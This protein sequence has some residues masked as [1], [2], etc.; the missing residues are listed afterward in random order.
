MLL[1]WHGVVHNV[2]ASQIPRTN[3]W[4]FVLI[5]VK[6]K[7]ITGKLENLSIL[8]KTLVVQKLNFIVA[9]LDMHTIAGVHG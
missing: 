3:N 6:K 4:S 5:T 7:L 2:L 9:F 8:A 1:V